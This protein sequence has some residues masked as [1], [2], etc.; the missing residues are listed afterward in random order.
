MREL[1]SD[2]ERWLG[3]AKVV[4][5]ATVVKV[6]GS[7]PRPLGSKMVVS[8][9]G[10]IAGSVSG[11]C[12]EAAV[13]EE[14]RA[15]MESGAPKLVRFDVTD[16]QV[17]AVGLTCGGELEVFIEGLEADRYGSL[18]ASIEAGETVTLAT[19]VGGPETGKRLL[20]HDDGSTEGH[21]GSRALDRQALEHAGQAGT[22]LEGRTVLETD[23][24]Q[25]DVYFEVQAPRPK[26]VLVG[27][28][29]VAI[30]LVTFANALGFRTIV[31]DHRTAFATPERFPHADRLIHK[32]PE[33]AFEE[34]GIDAATCVAT[35]SHDLK[36]DVPALTAA[37]RSSA[38][39]IGALGSKVT[40][41]TR[42]AALEEA[43]FGA[44]E[45]QRIKAPIGLDLGGRRAEE[46]ALSIIAE[47]VATRHGRSG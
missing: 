37:L 7:A 17:W 31:V 47:I 42:V 33:E 35:L 45:I 24:G 29:H 23:G 12:V 16:D 14:A 44:E 4:A 13:V 15:V 19:I 43:G 10:D 39:Y 36:L 22:R 27:A 6:W 8:S 46:I 1:L 20:V 41:K 18:K 40:H 21:L 2:I 9:A 11:G 25:H 3:E 30:P 32:R 38:S 28:V 5:L 34:I 26:L